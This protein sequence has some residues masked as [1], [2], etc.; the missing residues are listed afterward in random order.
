MLLSTPLENWGKYKKGKF[1]CTKL[2]RKTEIFIEIWNQAI[3]MIIR[4]LKNYEILFKWY[5][6]AVQSPVDKGKTILDDYELAKTF[7]TIFEKL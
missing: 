2:Y 4:L 5:L 3:L 7:N 1:S 6:F